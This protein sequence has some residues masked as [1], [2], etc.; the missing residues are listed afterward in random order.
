VTEASRRFR[1]HERLKSPEAFRRAFRRRR[2]E[3]DDILTVYG[4]ENGLE[5]VRLGISVSRKKIKAAN[6]RNRFKRLVREAFR[7]TKCEL[8][9][10]LDLVVIPRTENAD[11]AAVQ[12]SLKCLAARLGRRI[13]RGKKADRPPQSPPDRLSPAN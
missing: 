5:I 11:F 13:H 4:I 3:A 8:P 6:A 2:V 12:R 1:P 10:G 7:L 9:A